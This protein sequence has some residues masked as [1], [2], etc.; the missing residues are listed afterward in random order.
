MQTICFG[1]RKFNDKFSIVFL[2][3]LVSAEFRKP[4]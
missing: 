2:F 3:F 4:R 1:D